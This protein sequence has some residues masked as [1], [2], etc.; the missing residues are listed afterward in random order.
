MRDIKLKNGLL[1]KEAFENVKQK[2]G[3]IILETGNLSHEKLFQK[4]KIA[5]RLYYRR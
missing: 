1:L 3:E 4:L 5:M 2:S